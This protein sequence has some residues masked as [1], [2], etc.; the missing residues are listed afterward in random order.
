MKPKS[1]ELTMVRIR[2]DLKDKLKI[3]SVEH[4]LTLE[5]MLEKIIQEY[6]K[7]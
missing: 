7:R 4:L 1:N 2:K 3:K 6:L 5:K